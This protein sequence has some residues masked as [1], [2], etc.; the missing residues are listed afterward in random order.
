M[1]NVFMF[2]TQPE[3]RNN[4]EGKEKP[5]DPKS[6]VQRA[7]SND[8]E[9]SGNLRRSVGESFKSKLL[10]AS[11]PNQWHGFGTGKE[12]LKIKEGDITIIEGPNGPAMM[13]LADLKQQLCKPWENAL[14]L[15]IMGRNHTLNF[16]HAKLRQKWQLIGQWQLTDLEGGYFVVRF[17]M[18]KA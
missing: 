13:L 8:V 17:Q 6:S 14:I 16:M 15:K 5:P 7:Q 11:S 1:A 18:P 3:V 4:E 12:K 9:E 2:S 10:S